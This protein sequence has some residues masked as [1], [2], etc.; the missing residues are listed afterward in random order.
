VNLDLEGVRDASG[1]SA[2]GEAEVALFDCRLR[3]VLWGS[4]YASKKGRILA[5]DTAVSYLDRHGQTSAY[6][7]QDSLIRIEGGTIAEGTE[8]AG[9]VEGTVELSAVT[10]R[11]ADGTEM[12]AAEAPSK[13]W[14]VADGGRADPT[15]ETPRMPT[16]KI[17]DGERGPQLVLPPLTNKASQKLFDDFGVPTDALGTITVFSWW[18]SCFDEALAERMTI[19]VRGDEAVLQGEK[20]DLTRAAEHAVRFF[21]RTECVMGALIRGLAP[22]HPFAM[23]ERYMTGGA[24]VSV[25]TGMSLG[26]MGE[27]PVASTDRIA[28]A[29]QR[30]EHLLPQLRRDD[31][32]LGLGAGE[33]NLADFEAATGL[34]LPKE[35]RAFWQC[36]NGEKPSEAGLAAGFCL[37]SVE[38]AQQE[39]AGWA[40]V[41]ENLG[42]GLADLDQ[43]MTSHPPGAI[44]CKY[45]IDGWVPLAKD[46]EGNFIGVDLDPGPT[47]TIGQVINFGRDEENKRV[48]FLSVIEFIEWLA[49]ELEARRIVFDPEDNIII[50]VDG[51]LV[52][53]IPEKQS[54]LPKEA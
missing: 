27:R 33:Q 38:E 53:A 23:G 25:N 48:L 35:L 6:A 39:I 31:I 9:E 45:S 22:Q 46:H 16:I 30:F 43:S 32:K 5:V 14:I 3:D 15:A 11:L 2:M 12:P 24:S 8:S 13:L 49:L 18:V 29:W 4:L 1:V 26:A 20:N 40:I 51:R 28:A 52:S 10:V 54:S 34:T 47:G 37:M 7:R 41:R 19:V 42:D 44:Q 50:H 36:H 21:G 17:T